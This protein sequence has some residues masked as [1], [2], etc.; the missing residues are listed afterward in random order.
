MLPLE[1]DHHY[2]DLE[3]PDDLLRLEN[4]KLALESL[5]GLVVIDEVQRRPELFPLLRVLVDRPSMQTQFVILGSASPDLLRQNSE[6]LAGRIEY[7]ELSGFGISELGVDSWEKLWN[8][9]GFP[10][11]YLATTD[12]D[13]YEW[14]KQFAQT[15]LER[16]IAQMGVRLAATTLHRFWMMLAHRQGNIL[17]SS[18]LASSFGVSDHTVRH[19]ID[20][21]CDTFMLRQL[22]SWHENIT[23]RQVKSPKIYFRDSGLLHQFLG[24]KNIEALR[25]HPGLGAS[26][27]GF[28]LEQIMQLTRSEPSYFWATHGGAELDLLKWING[29]RI[30]FE[31]KYA[32][33][34]KPTKSMRIAIKD[35]ALKK[36]YIIH[37]GVSSYPID[38]VIHSVALRDLTRIMQ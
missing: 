37:P 27:E 5:S 8:R 17:N 30:G 2:F 14:R 18:E 32:D 29:E 7:I 23:K 24:I 4:P 3:D 19:Y 10:R 25:G 1:N 38:E 20:V 22:P 16:D 36:L 15:F 6:T 35:L 33:A 9:G 31:I 26:W 34:P 11:A 13:S 12:T 21:L 28:V